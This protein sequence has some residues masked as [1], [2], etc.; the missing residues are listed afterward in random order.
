MLVIANEEA[1]PRGEVDEAEEH[2]AV[3]EW[4]KNPNLLRN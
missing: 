2:R 4:E 1:V 3:R